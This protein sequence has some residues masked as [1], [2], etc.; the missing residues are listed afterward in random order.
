MGCRTQRET[1]LRPALTP[2][3]AVEDVLADAL[4]PVHGVDG[5]WTEHE[6]AWLRGQGQE[7]MP[8]GWGVGPS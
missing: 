8:W 2:H 6:G 5:P 7:E 4:I 1:G 3:N